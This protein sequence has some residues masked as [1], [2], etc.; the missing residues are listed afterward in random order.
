MIKR[1]QETKERAAKVAQMRA[2]QERRE[3]RRSLLVIAAAVAVSLLLAS[4]VGVVI[5]RE[6]N[7][8]AEQEAA[9]NAPIEGVEEF[10]NLPVN[11]VA[12]PVA[13]EQTPPTGGNHAGIWTNCGVYTKPLSNEQS[14]H[15]L[16]HGAVWVTYKPDLPA[17]QVEALTALVQPNSYGL[18]S[19]YDGLSSPVVA[20]AWGVQLTVEDANDPRLARFL[21]KYVQGEQAPEPGAPCTGGTG[22][23]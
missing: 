2:V 18:L 19:P 15:S 9:A 20:S 5:N 11:H 23:A 14:V 17:D 10:P 4:V 21:E 22:P 8:Q 6:L 12:G 16:E 7:R 1:K 13:Y 3:R